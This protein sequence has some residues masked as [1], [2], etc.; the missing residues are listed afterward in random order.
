MTRQDSRQ[1]FQKLQLTRQVCMA[2]VAATVLGVCG[3]VDAFE[4][5]TGDEDIVINWDNTLRYTLADRVRGKSSDIANSP[6]HNDGDRNFD[7]GIVSSRLDLL[8]E[9]D[10]VVK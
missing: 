4:I 9:I 2:L 5:N 3:S 6:N 8:S 7:V 1:R 10:V